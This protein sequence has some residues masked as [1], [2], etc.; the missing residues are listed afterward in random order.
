MWIRVLIVGLLLSVVGGRTADA[1]SQDASISA[2]AINAVGSYVHF[3]IF[4]DV[5]VAVTN[6]LVRLDGRVT[7]PFKREDIGK[8]V[9]RIAGVREVINDIEVLP[10]LGTDIDLRRAI[11]AAI[12]GHPAFWQYASMARPPIHI[13]VERGHVRLTG[14]VT[15]LVEQRLAYALAQV[16]GAFTVTNELRVEK[17]EH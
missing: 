7:M 17:A 10:L 13:I 6:G 8:R 16:S 11:A 3:S 14:A 2:A 4:D 5:T 15:S 12:Y 1:Q 9:A